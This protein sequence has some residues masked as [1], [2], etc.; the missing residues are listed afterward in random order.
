MS[1]SSTAL[2]ALEEF[3]EVRGAFGSYRKSSAY[4]R[5]LPAPLVPFACIPP[6]PHLLSRR[7]GT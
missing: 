6:P 3:C 4:F 5:T 7:N 2:T 1:N